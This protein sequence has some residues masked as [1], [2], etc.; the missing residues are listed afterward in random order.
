MYE[1]KRILS[2]GDLAGILL[3][4][5]TRSSFF[6]IIFDQSSKITPSAVGAGEA[7]KVDRDREDAT[8]LAAQVS[9]VVS[10]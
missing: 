5:T 8:L 1:V 10:L 6:K 2:V 4:S 7:D 9:L 3:S